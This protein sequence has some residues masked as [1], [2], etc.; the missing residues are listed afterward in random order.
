MNRYFLMILSLLLGAVNMAAEDDRV[1]VRT[2][3]LIFEASSTLTQHY[4]YVEGIL[5]ARLMAA[6]KTH[7]L[8]FP[9]T[10]EHEGIVYDVIGFRQDL[11]EGRESDGI[12]KV[13]LPERFSTLGSFNLCDM[14]DLEEIVY[15]GQFLACSRDNFINLPKLKNFDFSKID[16]RLGDHTFINVGLESVRFRYDGYISFCEGG[17]SFFGNFWDMPNLV[18]IDLA[19]VRYTPSYTFINLPKLEKLVF[20]AA[21]ERVGKSSFTDLENLQSITFRLRDKGNGKIGFDYNSFT[22]TPKLKDVYVEDT[23]PFEFSFYADEDAFYP[24]RY[25]LHVPR[26]SKEFY[27]AAPGWKEFGK[28]VEDGG[29]GSS[30]ED[31]TADTATWNCT[32][33]TGG[34]A[35]T[36]AEGMEILVATMDGRIMERLT[37]ITGCTT[38][39]LPAGLYIVSAAGQSA[40]ICVK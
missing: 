38:I 6:C 11:L 27:A 20:N 18:D 35:V 34:V 22:N 21:L 15:N 29:M 17:F 30:I 19:D 12:K 14:A 3:G 37:A 26:G 8:E 40:K 31:A 13:I 4:A 9:N 28:I 39:N 2:D 10:I 7:V 23:T 1:I 24:A 16:I 36:G 33:V 25:T 32:A 5:D